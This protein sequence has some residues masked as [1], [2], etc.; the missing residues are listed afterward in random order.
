M[1]ISLKDIADRV[2]VSKATVSIYLND[3]QTRRVGMET[4][5]KIDIVIK[6][7]NYRPNLLAKSLSTSRSRMLGVLIPSVKP[8]FTHIYF[9]SILAG[10]QNIASSREFSLLFL[11]TQGADPAKILWN[12]INSSSGV[13]GYFL[14]GNIG[15]SLNDYAKTSQ[16]LI[17]LRTPF[18]TV[19]IPELDISMNQVILQDSG[20]LTALEHLIQLGHKRIAIVLGEEDDP[21]T[22]KGLDLYRSF[23]IRHGLNFDP[24]L[25]YYGGYDRHLAKQQTLNLFRDKVEFTAVFCHSDSMA[26]GVY[27]A[28]RE[29]G[30]SIPHDVSVIGSND[31]FFAGFMTPPLSTI[32]KQSYTAGEYAAEILLKAIETGLNNR[33]VYLDSHLILR[34]STSRARKGL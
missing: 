34:G 1:G 31:D 19:N 16:K 8:P 2:G 26:A 9:S 13:E 22:N 27:E 15:C 28:V 6:E 5:K 3:P 33:K 17:D 30:Y 7:L 10:L 32:K 11:P 24:R 4:K 29:A 18:V 23:L 25:I 21:S 20:F 12:Q 14:F